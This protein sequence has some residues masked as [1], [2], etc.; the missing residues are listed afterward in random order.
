MPVIGVRTRRPLRP[1]ASVPEHSSTSTAT[2]VRPGV[3]RYFACWAKFASLIRR[4]RPRVPLDNLT[5]EERSKCMRSVHSKDTQ[6]EMLVRRLV[7]RMGYRYRLH[8]TDLPGRP[9][10]VFGSRKKIIFVHGCFW[11]GHACDNRGVPKSRVSYWRSKFLR[12]IKRDN[13]ALQQLGDLGWKCLVLWECELRDDKLA[14][15]IARFLGRIVA[16]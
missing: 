15:R 1:T 6:P 16:R 7:H 2:R 4:S 3:I 14:R 5:K 13:R 9:D 12:N 11:H 10:L 8:R